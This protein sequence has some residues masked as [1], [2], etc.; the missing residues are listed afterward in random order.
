MH[1]GS[2]MCKVSRAFQH[3]KWLKELTAVFQARTG[4]RIHLFNYLYLGWLFSLFS[5]LTVSTSL[6]SKSV[7]TDSLQIGPSILFLDSIYI[8]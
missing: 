4:E 8:H 1:I 2:L 7:S 5:F 3:I 6:F